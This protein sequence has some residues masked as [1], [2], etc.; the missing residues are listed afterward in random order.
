MVSLGTSDTLILWIDDPKPST[1]GH[2]FVNPIND[3]AFM[4][5]LW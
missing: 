1:E 5:L 4:A 2:I 3:N